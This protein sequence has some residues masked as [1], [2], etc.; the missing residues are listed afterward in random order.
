MAPGGHLRQPVAIDLV[1]IHR[2]IDQ[3]VTVNPCGQITRDF[4]RL[5]I[6]DLGMKRGTRGGTGAAA[7]R[8]DQ[9]I[10]ASPSMSSSQ[11]ACAASAGRAAAS[12][13]IASGPRSPGTRMQYE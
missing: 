12:G 3:G 7:M 2:E 10:G 1:T 11:S 6:I 4:R 8:R 9:Q 13:S 5:Q